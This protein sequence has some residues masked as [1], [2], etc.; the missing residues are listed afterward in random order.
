M[1]KKTAKDISG[2][3]LDIGDK[4]FILDSVDYPQNFATVIASLEIGDVIDITDSGVIINIKDINIEYDSN[5]IGKM[6]P[7]ESL[8]DTIVHLAN[9]LETL[10]L[11]RE[12]DI[13]NSMLREEEE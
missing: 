13:L 9:N 7:D 10:Q 3:K 8:D 4:V 12:S 1:K 11:I 6:N 5:K 2:R